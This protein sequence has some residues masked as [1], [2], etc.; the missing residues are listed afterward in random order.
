MSSPLSGASGTLMKLPEYYAD[1]EKNFWQASD[2]WKLERGQV[3]AEPGDASWEAFYRGNWPDAMFLL[4]D[5][6]AD[7]KK[8]HDETSGCGPSTRRVRIV[9]LPLTPYL[10]WEL[11]LL[12]IRD[13]TGG[14]VRILDAAKVAELEQDGPLPE[15]YT[16]DTS[17]MYEAIYDDFGVLQN[18]RKFTDESLVRGCRDLIAGLY[19]LAEPISSFFEREVAKLPPPAMGDPVIGLDYLQETGRPGPIRS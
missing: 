4:D 6:R 16:M 5:R 15:I 9:S 7:L 10:Q 18:A 2:F 13:E 19:D 3:F 12:K 17:A 14:P 8:Y 1:F 11:E